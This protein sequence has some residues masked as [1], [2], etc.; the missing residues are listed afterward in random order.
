M[1]RG[2]ER[3]LTILGAAEAWALEPCDIDCDVIL[4]TTDSG[5]SWRRFTGP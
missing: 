3:Q 2:R 1:R 4:H 5:R